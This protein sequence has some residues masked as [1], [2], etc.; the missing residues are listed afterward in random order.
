MKLCKDCKHFYELESGSICVRRFGVSEEPV[1]G[2]IIPNRP[3]Q[4]CSSERESRTD[5]CGP[6]G[7]YWEAKE[8]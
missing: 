1:Y 3:L 8:V 4:Y 6:E 7:Q 2:R 5:L